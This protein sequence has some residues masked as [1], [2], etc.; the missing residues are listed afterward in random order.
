ML[1]LAAQGMGRTFDKSLSVC[2]GAPRANGRNSCRS[3]SIFWSPL[4]YCVYHVLGSIPDWLCGRFFR[5]GP[6]KYEVGDTRFNHW[7]DGL[8]MLMCFNIRNGNDRHSSKLMSKVTETGK[9]TFQ[10]KFLRS[11][12]YQKCM[13]ANRIVVSGMG[14]AAHPD[15]CKT[16]FQR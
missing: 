16:I 10:S 15:P 2:R 4:Y 11:R 8:A 12:V 14:T 3:E 5:C 9:A 13:A 6:A 1:F 7:F